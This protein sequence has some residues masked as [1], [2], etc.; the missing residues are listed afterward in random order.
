MKKFFLVATTLFICVSALKAQTYQ[1]GLKAIDF[2]KYEAGRGIFKILITK[3]PANGDLYYYLGQCYVN[4]LNV[5]S[6]SLS[7]KEG[8][9]VAPTNP[10]NYAGLGELELIA[11]H[12]DKAK[13]YFDKALSFY[14][15]KSGIYTD[16]RA[17]T[18]VASSMVNNEVVKMLD[19]AETLIKMGYDQDK[20]DYNLLIAAGDVYLERNDGGSSATFYERAIAVDPKNPK[21][22]S[23]VAIIWLR[24]KNYESAQADLNRS[25]EKDSNYA[26]ALK[27]QAEL[28]YAQHKFEKAKEAYNKYLQNSEPS[29]A[30][31]TR[32]ARILFLSK[33]YE[34]ALKKIEEIQKMDTSS[35]LLYRFRAFSTYEVIA[36]TNNVNKATEG[37]IAL[38]YYMSRMDP[39]K[40]TATD[41]EYLGKLQSKIPGM[42]SI[43]MMNLNK[44]LD[45]NPFNV[46]VFIDMA[47]INYKLKKFD[48]S[49]A[50]YETYLVKAKKVQA[51]DYFQLGK[52]YYFA[53]KFIKADSA[54]IKVNEMVPNYPDAYLWRGNSNANLDPGNKTDLAKENYEKYITILTSDTLKFQTKKESFKPNLIIAYDYLGNYYLQK[55]NKTMAKEF[56]RKVLELDPKNENAKSVVFEKEKEKNK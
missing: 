5:D 8:V 26:P 38:T 33:E 35:L 2:E 46:D 21:A 54:F 15:N 44:S 34:E 19:E 16:I 39:K 45:M 43:A 30:N 51:A 37:L 49:A 50:N 6:A 17:I 9:K 24:V 20:K 40:I 32:F 56:Y 4:L 41:Y 53:K 36:N 48:A 47:K 29:I 18:L 42:D 31:Q 3:E 14:K 55:D 7:Y 23:K 22:Y 52:S 12:K 10:A 13:E 11:D 28:Y 25:F 27:Y 1:D